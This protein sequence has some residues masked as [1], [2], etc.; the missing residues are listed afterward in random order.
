MYSEGYSC[1]S[2]FTQ[3]HVIKYSIPYKNIHTVG[4]VTYYQSLYYKSVKTYM[5]TCLRVHVYTIVNDVIIT[6]CLQVVG[7]Y[8]YVKE[9]MDIEE[10]LEKVTL[11][12]GRRFEEPDTH[13]W[14]ITAITKLISQLGHMPESVQNQIALYLTS[15][16][17]DIQQVS[18]DVIYRIAGKFCWCKCSP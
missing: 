13:G 5:Y 15:T 6:S 17:T 14:V 18:C 7:E 4:V 8:A 9:D 16:N 12:L 10:I 11:L 3:R 2:L 1:T